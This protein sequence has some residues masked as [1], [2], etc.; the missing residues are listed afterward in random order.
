MA[1]ADVGLVMTQPAIGVV[2][3]CVS[4]S[5]AN[6]ASTEFCTMAPVVVTLSYTLWELTSGRWV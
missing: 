6:V 2:I 5:P 3:A 1:T 4:T